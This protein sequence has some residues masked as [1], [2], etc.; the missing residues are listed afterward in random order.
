M[1]LITRHLTLL[2][3]LFQIGFIIIPPKGLSV[4][5]FQPDSIL[6]K[7]PD[8]IHASSPDTIIYDTV[9]IVKEPI[10]IR[11]EIF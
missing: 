11:K 2:M 5:Q 1:P 4:F 8:S 6:K 10:I 3:A 7:T 9:I